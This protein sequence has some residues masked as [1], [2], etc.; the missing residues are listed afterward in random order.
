MTELSGYQLEPLQADGDYVLCRGR[1]SDEHATILVL[2]PVN[3]AGSLGRLQ[4]EVSL[5][6]DLD[7]EWAARP[8]GLARHEGRTVLVL[9]DPGGEPLSRLVGGAL[10]LGALLGIAIGVAA[11]LHRVHERGLVHRDIKPGN[12]LVDPARGT[13]RLTG[14]GLASR[15]P[16]ERQAARPPEVIAGTLAYM[17]PEQTGR[18]NR[19]VDLRSDLYS[20]GVTLYELLT[21][22][23]PF[24]ASDAMELVHCHIARQPVAPDERVAAIPGPLAGIV[25]KLMAKTAEERYQSAGAVEADLRRCLDAWETSGHIAPF[26]LGSEDASDR[27]VVPEKLYGRQADIEALVAAFDRVVAEGGLEIV[28]VSGYPGVGKSSVVNELHKVV[29]APHGLFASGKVDQHKRDIPYATLAEAFGELVRQILAA[30]EAEV[31]R[32]RA[33]LREAV[34]QSGQLIVS[35]IP[36]VEFLI[37]KQAP[38]PTLAPEDA[39][40]RF[41]R[42]FRRFLEVFARPEHPLALFLD[43]LQWLDVATLDLLEHVVTE[44]AVRH[45]LLVG[46][47]RDNEVGP[48]HPLARRLEAMRRT[49]VRT[50]EIRLAPLLLED[51]NR[52]VA[53]ALRCDLEHAGPLAALMHEKAGGNPFFTIQFFT[54]L[55]DRGLVTFDRRA[56]AWR[57]DVERIYALGLTDNVA[58]LMVDRLSRLPPATQDALGQLACLGNVADLATLAL[59]HGDDFGALHSALWPAVA[60]G[61]VLS[62]ERGYTFLHDRVQEAA[63]SLVAADRKAQA[64]LRIGTLLAARM[65]PGELEEHIFEVVNQVNRAVALLVTPEERRDVAAL[66]LLAGKRAKTANAHES[67]SAYLA[68]GRALLGDGA[69]EAEPTLTFELELHRAENEFLTGELAAADTRLALLSGRARDIADRAAVARLR[70]A[71]QTTLDR[72][73]RAVDVCL[74]YLRHVGIDWSPHPGDAEV[75]AEHERLWQRLA[76]RTVEELIDLPL[77]T[78]PMWRATLDLLTSVQGP[79]MFTDRNLLG[80]VAARMA[81]LSLEHGHCDGSAFAYVW[82][83]FVL[84]SRFGDYSNGFRFGRLGLDLV[85]RRGLDRFKPRVYLAFGQL[86]NPWVMHLGTSRDLLRRAFVAAREHG[87][88]TYAAYGCTNLVT[89][90]LGTGDP[91]ADVEEEAANGLAFARQARFGLVAAF[92]TTQLGLVRSLRGRTA[93]L[94]SFT[95]GELVEQ[96]LEDDLDADPRL[97]IAACWYW[98]RKLQARFHAGDYVAAVGAGRRAEK[99][100]WSTPAQ[101]EVAEYH[102]HDALARAALGR[103]EAE[104]IAAHLQQL[105]IWARSCPDNFA[106]RAAL[107]AA[108]L[109]RVEGRVLDAEERYEAAIRAARESGLVQI[110]ALAHELGAAFW[111]ARGFDAFAVTYLRSART[112]YVAWGALGKVRQL[113]ARHPHLVDDGGRALPVAT[114]GE[115]DVATV[116]KAAQILSGEIVLDRLIDKLM[117]IAIEHAG[118][119]RGLLV[120]VRRGEATIAAEATMRGGVLAVSPPRQTGL[121]AELPGS[122]LHYVMRTRAPVILDDATVPN[123]FSGDPY[124]RARQPR[125]VLLLPLLKQA[126]LIGVLYLE[127]NLAAYAFTPARMGVLTLLASQAAISLENAQLYADLQ[128]VEA[129]LAEGQRLSQTGSFGWDV[130]SG[131]VFWSD[132]TFAIFAYDRA[133][134]PSLERVA[135]RTH[136]DDRERLRELVERVTRDGS[137]WI[138][139]HRLLL[140]GGEVKSLRV[141]ARAV[142]DR[143]GRLEYVG[144]VTDVTATRRAEEILQASLEEKEALLKEVHHRVKNNLQLISSLLNLQARSVDDPATAELFADS[145]NRVRSMAL[146]HENLYRAGNFARVPMAAHIQ[147]L[148]AQLARAYGLS[149]QPVELAVRVDDVQLILDRAIVCGLIVNELV[150][151]ALKHAFPGGRGGRIDVELRAGDGGRL[152]LSVA[153]D[154]I[155][156]SP[157]ER[158]GTPGSLGLDLVDDLVGQLHGELALASGAGTRFT[159]SFGA[160]SEE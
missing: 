149:G 76:G 25:M 31:A 125:S 91:L 6:A 9:E 43:D 83:G 37:G 108:E 160:E 66:N 104:A 127:N 134:V 88:L 124:V 11:A 56:R 77:M 46:A 20:L 152:Q 143:A 22:A 62:S 107:V 40:D 147:S 139:D 39:Q 71:L 120:L 19:S 121:A 131:A 109:A 86:V 48:T 51:V 45:L 1:R 60:I 101:F 93:G 92:L 10:D 129:Y 14:F 98:I 30:S 119:Q 132:E 87:D 47:Y 156:L 35:L 114:A 29:V 64:H 33:A 158:D 94:G 49:G 21:G 8:L 142:R 57:W 95:D 155:G 112:C 23:L 42:V 117:A 118:A 103:D 59:V 97:A 106:A 90:L 111:A 15:L 32:W 153:D 70:I 151:N 72:S 102:F 84:G 96:R 63:Y 73:D 154:G 12:V 81:N 26:S 18:M 157:R 82:L 55:A 99:L 17:S 68:T 85:D 69:W 110:E 36:E 44:P 50:R 148:C 146:V 78:D 16:R 58:E 113:D 24:T 67:A 159:V 150:S 38:I 27:L 28:L 54:A 130:A 144:A 126:E 136:P 100:L 137:D 80:L 7:P 61:L 41:R 13:A 2:V 4:H 122:A 53:D 145:R 133:V 128:R 3:P 135:E 79:A 115:L 140:P 65:G 34:G 116:M 52:L 5:A 123:R 74:E 141:T 89:N 138:F 105:E 75:E